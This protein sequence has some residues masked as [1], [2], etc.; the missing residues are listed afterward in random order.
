M[1]TVAAL[2]V[3]VDADIT[4]AT[5]GLD[6]VEQKVTGMGSRIGQVFS[7]AGGFLLARGVEAVV[8]SVGGLVSTALDFEQQMANVNSIAQLSASELQVLS[9]QVIGLTSNPGIVDGPAKLAQGLMDIVGA[10]FSGAEG[11]KILE[12][13]ALGAAAGVTET[14]VATDALTSVLNAYKLTADDAM[15]ITDQMFKAVD[16]GKLSFEQLASNLG[17][18]VPVAASL[19]I[20][21]GQLGAAYALM[22]QQGIGASQAETQISA[23]MRSAL[24]PTEQLTAAVQ[25]HGFASAT[26]AIEAE[27]LGGYLG[28]LTEESGGSQE[29]LFKMLGTTEA[30]NAAVALGGDNLDTYIDFLQQMGLASEGAGATQTALN[31][32][33][34]SANF[35]IAKMKQQVAT[36]ATVF[37]GLFAPGI[38]AGAE[39]LT[40][41]LSGGVIPFTNVISQA[42]RG[43][44]EFRDVVDTLPQPLRRTAGAVGTIAEGLGDLVRSFSD[45]GFSGTLDTLFYG[46]EGEQI[47]GGLKTIAEEGWGLFTDTLGDLV[48]T[49]VTLLPVAVT[50][51]ISLGGDIG[52]ASGRLYRWV[53]AKLFAGDSLPVSPDGTGGPSPTGDLDSIQISDVVVEG[54]IQLMGGISKATGRLKDWIS[55]QLFGVVAPD[56]TGG[57]SPHGAGDGFKYEIAS[58]TFDI[59]D[60]VIDVSAEDVEGWIEDRFA[61][62]DV[63]KPHLE[64]WGIILSG[65]PTVEDD[66]TWGGGGD[67]DPITAIN[68]WVQEKADLL[69]G[70]NGLAI[71]ATNWL[72][73]VTGH[74]EKADITNFDEWLTLVED[75]IES[76]LSAA[77]S[78]TADINDVIMKIPG[79]DAVTVD[80]GFE[81]EELAN[82]IADALPFP[83]NIP[84]GIILDILL[85]DTKDGGGTTGTS[86]TTTTGT[87]NS[88]RDAFDALARDRNFVTTAAGANWFAALGAATNPQ[89]YEDTWLT[90]QLYPQQGPQLPEGERVV[91]ARLDLNTDDAK[92]KM[93]DLTGGHEKIMPRDGAFSAV[94]DLDTKKANTKKTEAMLWGDT[95]MASTFSGIFDG[96]NGPAALKYTDAFLWGDTW[97]AQTFTARFSVDLGPLETAKTRVAE[98]AQEI[99]DLLP[100]SPAKRG[101]L[102]RPIS[103]GYIAD[104]LERNLDRMAA[105]ASYGMDRVGG[106]FNQ[107]FNN[108]YAAAGAGG[109][110]PGVINVYI[111][112]DSKQFTEIA[113]KAHRGGD[114]ARELPQLLR[115]V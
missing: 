22:T 77:E 87:S 3:K 49:G 69:N 61:E 98:L 12:A 86:N 109:Q 107:R 1:P 59:L 102:A 29:A 105:A 44:F 97:A 94:F 50:G 100:H 31:K 35:Q 83:L 51:A 28:I 14:A 68:N 15:G 9:D 62:W 75:G 93:L 53:K 66:G 11:I 36:A 42:V 74:P 40:G 63:I 110:T 34:L 114:F 90:N 26:A 56:G 76:A 18:T 101:P 91:P 106:A 48:D 60:A 32:Q 95:W 112:P 13:A 5:R 8:G 45:R 80:I 7:T 111:T 89:A 113:E 71:D 88:M 52:D 55:D 47:L 23:L 64:S 19:G 67:T 54:G 6:V 24:A 41:F 57:P 85:G 30:M 84:A 65:T 103:F 16:L 58:V 72:M 46:G 104:D 115:G 38:R 17:N 25:K 27:G 39:A 10:G 79:I 33:M 4:S 82:K 20:E 99:S 96:D 108:A 43:G 81:M 2:T 92:A 73:E 37:F 21:F 70:E 78:I